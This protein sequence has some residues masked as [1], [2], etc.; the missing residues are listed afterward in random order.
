M[1]DP[2]F[3]WINQLRDRLDTF[4][5]AKQPAKPT[6][7]P[8]PH[9]PKRAVD[10]DVLTP[11]KKAELT[12]KAK[13]KVAARDML[14]A[15]EAFLKAEMEK[16]ERELHPEVFV[17]MR[18]IR[19]DIALYANKVVLDGKVYFANELYTVPKPVYDV[20]KEIECNSFRHEREIRSGNTDDAFYRKERGT[21][22]NWRTGQVVNGPAARF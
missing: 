4:L 6:V 9:E 16:H 7:V 8:K 18:E 19:L 21:Q 20:L 12:A 15:E 22:L 11:E 14:D 13:A 1:A 3:G 17:E 2:H 5:M 10:F